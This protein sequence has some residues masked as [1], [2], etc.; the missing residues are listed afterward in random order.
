M[1]F[2]IALCILVM[3]ITYM[4][5]SVEGQCNKYGHSCH[6]GQGRSESNEQDPTLTELREN[7]D[8]SNID[9]REESPVSRPYE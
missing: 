4:A 8:E 7:A 3:C 2:S 6:G 1:K 5:N 9:S